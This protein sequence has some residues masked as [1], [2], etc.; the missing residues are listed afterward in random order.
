MSMLVVLRCVGIV[1][2][3]DPCKSTFVI[4]LS[5]VAPDDHFIINSNLLYAVFWLA[6]VLFANST[7]SNTYDHQRSILIALS[8]L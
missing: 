3:E 7:L 5:C 2:N 6:P 8:S 4:V 1:G